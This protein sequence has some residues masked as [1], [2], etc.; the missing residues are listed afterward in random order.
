MRLEKSCFLWGVL[1][2]RT[3]RSSWRGWKEQPPKERGEGYCW[4]GKH[5]VQKPWG[6]KGSGMLRNW[7]EAGVELGA[8][9]PQGLEWQTGRGHTGHREVWFLL[10]MWWETMRRRRVGKWEDPLAA[11]GDVATGGPRAAAGG[12][13]KR[14]VGHLSPFPVPD[15]S[16]L[17]ARTLSRRLSASKHNLFH[18]GVVWTEGTWAHWPVI[19]KHF[20]LGTPLHP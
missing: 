14:D 4:Q 15:S 5:H 19:L 8:R 1:T 16:P 12:I 2:H 7:K 10:R 11:G 20:G 18:C 6:G 13:Q 17:F 3:W 9:G